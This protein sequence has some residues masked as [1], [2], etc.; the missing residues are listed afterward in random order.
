MN[1]D[2]NIDINTRNWVSNTP[3]IQK[4]LVGLVALQT[5]NRLEFG[6]NAEMHS[7]KNL[8]KLKMG[9]SSN[10]LWSALNKL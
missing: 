8:P 7:R 4:V 10:K 5:S 6:P 2:T 1:I 9:S 3:K